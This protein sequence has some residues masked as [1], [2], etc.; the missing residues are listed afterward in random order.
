LDKV[1]VVI[2]S[3]GAL[4]ASV[5]CWFTLTCGALESF[6]VTVKVELPVV[7]G[8]PERMPTPDESPASAN[9]AG[10]LPVVTLQLIGNVPPLVCMFWL[11]EVPTVPAGSDVVVMLSAGLIVRL[12]A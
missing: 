3:G 12:S 7:V 11:Y 5:N 9:P 10:K 2:V 1:V 8:V 6:A 4:T